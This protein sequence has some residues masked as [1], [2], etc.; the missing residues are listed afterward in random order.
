VNGRITASDYMN[1]LGSQVYPMVQLLFPNNDAIFQEDDSPH[2]H[3]QKCSVLVWGAW[4][5]TSTS[6]VAS[7]VAQ[8]KYCRTTVVSYREQSEKQIS[9]IIPQA[10]SKSCTVFSTRD[11]SELTWVYSKNNT[12]CVRGK[13]WPNSILIKKYVF[14]IAVSIIFSIPCIW[15]QIIFHGVIR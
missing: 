13:W 5:C 2:T 8:L 6:S 4:R 11:Y 14:F 1:I 9:S 15:C 3:T 10:S 7:T 12:S